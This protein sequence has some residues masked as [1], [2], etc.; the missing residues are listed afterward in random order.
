MSTEKNNNHKLEKLTEFINKTANSNTVV[1]KDNNNEFVAYSKVIDLKTDIEDI[2]ELAC[3]A[4]EM[5]YTDPIS[6]YTVFTEISHLKRGNCCGNGCRH[7]PYNHINVKSNR[8][9][10]SK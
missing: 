7:C 5:T 8:K 9:K 3:L 6:G 2:H 4:G 1:E 10:Y